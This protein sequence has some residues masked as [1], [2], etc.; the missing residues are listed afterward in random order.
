MQNSALNT[1]SRSDKPIWYFLL[2]WTILNIIQSYTLELHPDEAYYWI[3][4]RLLDWG[5][6]DH[7]PMVAIFI[8]IGDAIMHNELGLRLMTILASSTSIYLLW[9]TLKR[10]AVDARWFILVMSGILIFHIYGFTTTPDV[11][12]FLF[13]TLF[14]FIYQKYIDDDKLKWALLLAVIIAWLLYSKYHGVL[15]IVFTVVSNIKLLKRPSFYIIV[16]LAAV[17]Y[18]PHILWQVNHNYPSLTY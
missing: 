11:P 13:T 9:L 14:Y 18:I 15:L 1:N 8:R 3:Y 7:P 2:F 17:L 16:V 10:Y 5:Y 12:L 6:Y 4:A